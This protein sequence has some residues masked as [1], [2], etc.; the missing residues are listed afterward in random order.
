M[1]IVNVWA[2]LGTWVSYANL[3]AHSG[4]PRGRTYTVK[5]T[6]ENSQAPSSFTARDPICGF[7]WSGDGPS[8]GGGGVVAGVGQLYHSLLRW[9]WN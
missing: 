8:T 5:F 4:G 1:A 3:R 2:P 6:T 9:S 7:E